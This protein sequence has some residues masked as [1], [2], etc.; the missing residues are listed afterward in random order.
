[1][2]QLDEED[3]Q[4]LSLLH[5]SPSDTIEAIPTV[6]GQQNIEGTKYTMMMQLVEANWTI[7]GDCPYYGVGWDPI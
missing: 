1:M 7:E 2:M 5:G 4:W 6:D 3:G